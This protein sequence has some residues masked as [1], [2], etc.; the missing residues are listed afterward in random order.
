MAVL[1]RRLEQIVRS[2]D[3]AEYLAVLTDTGSDDVRPDV[4]AADGIPFVAFGRP[5]GSEHPDSHPWVDV[6]GNAGSAESAAWLRRLGHTAI[7]FLGWPEGSGVGDD[8]RAGWR[9]AVAGLTDSEGLSVSVLDDHPS[10]GAEGAAELI[11]RGATAIVCA[12]DS[13]ALGALGQLRSNGRLDHPIAP[14]VG[15]DDTPVARA[16]GLSSVHQPVEDAA[17]AVLDLAISALTG[18]ARAETGRLLRPSLVTRE[19][20]AFAR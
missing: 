19:L 20:A 2:G 4:L 8:R 12:S 16:L 17:V 5:W 1:L 13:L 11:A 3:P 14:L 9:R 18:D 10:A 15:F 6:D 7:G